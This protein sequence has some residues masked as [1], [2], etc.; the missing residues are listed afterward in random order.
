MPADAGFQPSTVRND[1]TY[2][3]DAMVEYVNLCS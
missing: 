2:V 1:L 3:L